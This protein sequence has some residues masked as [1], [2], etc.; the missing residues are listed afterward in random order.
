MHFKSLHFHFISLAFIYTKTGV[1]HVTTLKYF[2]WFPPVL[3]L[4]GFGQFRP[5]RVTH[6]TDYCKIRHGIHVSYALPSFTLT[7]L[8]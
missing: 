3:Q 2:F 8:F 7:G 1:S 5:R 4:G 6:C